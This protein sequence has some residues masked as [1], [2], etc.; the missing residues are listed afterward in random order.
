LEGKKLSNCRHNCMACW[1]SS[2]M[3]WM[4]PER[5]MWASAPP[6]ASW[7]ISSPVTCLMTWGPVMNIRAWRVW[8][9][10][11]VRAGL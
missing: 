4:L 7:E 5:V 2:A 11:S 10:K 8:M 3:K 1:S 6:R 9:M